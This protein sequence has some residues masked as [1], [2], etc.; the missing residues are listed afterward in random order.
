MKKKPKGISLK[1]LIRESG[2]NRYQVKKLLRELEIEGVIR[3]HRKRG[4][5]LQI[6]IL[7]KLD[8]LDEKEEKPVEV[9]RTFSPRLRP[10]QD[11]WGP[12][13]DWIVIKRG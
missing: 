1:E 11:V 12:E 2:L 7:E 5:K 8:V 4:A 10:R 9:E 13:E 6:D 3:I